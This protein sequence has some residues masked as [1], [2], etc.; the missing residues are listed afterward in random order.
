MIHQLHDPGT[1]CYSIRTV[2]HS[3]VINNGA[4][5]SSYITGKK[6]NTRTMIKRLILLSIN[7][8]ALVLSGC[9]DSE[10][11]RNPQT[12]G[13][14]TSGPVDGRPGGF[15]QNPGESYP[16]PEI[17]YQEFVPSYH[18]WQGTKCRTWRITWP[19]YDSDYDKDLIPTV[20]SLSSSQLNSIEYLNNTDPQLTYN[21]HLSLYNDRIV[22]SSD[23]MLVSLDHLFDTEKTM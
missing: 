4:L 18:L 11:Q 1:M 15:Q 5:Q 13:G 2:S 16:Y 10:I 17:I 7:F 22:Y 21:S 23:N 3:F 12:I 8:T 19:A 20:L 6:L 14:K 9:M